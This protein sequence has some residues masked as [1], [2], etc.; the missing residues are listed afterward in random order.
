MSLHKG[1]IRLQVSS[2][3]S[4]RADIGNRSIKSPEWSL[5]NTG[6]VM[7][8]VSRSCPM[9]R[10]IQHCLMETTPS[11]ALEANSQTAFLRPSIPQNE[12]K[13]LVTIDTGLGNCILKEPLVSSQ[14]LVHNILISNSWRQKRKHLNISVQNK[15]MK[16]AYD[17]YFK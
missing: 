13:N 16:R 12:I 17:T 11:T 4:T 3:H 2:S 6:N 15:S 9:S 5:C 8:L 7:A 14:K 1:L 10:V